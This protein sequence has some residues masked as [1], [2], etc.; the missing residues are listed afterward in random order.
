MEE[1]GVS[2]NANYK[3]CFMLD[4]LAMITVA[5]PNYGVIEVTHDLKLWSYI[6]NMQPQTMEL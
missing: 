1:L 5:T 4:S 6:S 2:K 3:L